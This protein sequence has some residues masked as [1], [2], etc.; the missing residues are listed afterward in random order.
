MKIAG[1]LDIVDDYGNHHYTVSRKESGCYYLV[2][3]TLGDEHALRYNENS[4]AV[5][6]QLDSGV[7]D[8]YS[9]YVYQADFIRR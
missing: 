1:W 2:Q 8:I 9:P 6:E 5:E 3:K 4:G 7:W